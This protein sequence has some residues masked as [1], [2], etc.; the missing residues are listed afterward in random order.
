M[1]EKETAAAP[2]L[3]VCTAPDLSI[4]CQKVCFSSPTQDIY[5]DKHLQYT[6]ISETQCS[7]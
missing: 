5:D 1:V 3:M 7:Q 2:L 6:Q 4:F